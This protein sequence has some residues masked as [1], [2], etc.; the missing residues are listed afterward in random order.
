[1]E[2]FNVTLEIVQNFIR[3]NNKSPINIKLFCLKYA[4]PNA[5][6]QKYN[7]RF[8][9]DNIVLVASQREWLCL[10]TTPFCC[11]V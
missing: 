7:G 1:M 4:N 8:A 11:G 3:S 5:Y 2:K 6:A 10:S 9:N